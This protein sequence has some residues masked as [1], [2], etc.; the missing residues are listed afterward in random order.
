MIFTDIYLPALANE[1]FL[2]LFCLSQIVLYLSEH[3]AKNT[4][5]FIAE[6]HRRSYF[7]ETI[8][9]FIH[10]VVT[11]I[12]CVLQLSFNNSWTRIIYSWSAN[13]SCAYFT[14]HGLNYVIKPDYPN[15]M[16]YALHHLLGFLSV[17]PITNLNGYYLNDTGDTEC[18]DTVYFV[19]A[20]LHLVEISTIWLDARIFAQLWLKRKLYFA[21]TVLLVA[22]YFPLRVIWLAYLMYIIGI[23]KQQ[24]DGCFGPYAVYVLFTTF[25]FILLMSFVYSITMLRAGSRFFNLKHY[26]DC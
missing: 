25:G 16:V 11:S 5:K 10:A 20:G 26:K 14:V 18:S 4:K 8:L 21:S 17:V 7:A 24:F 1:S 6:A 22:T 23:S 3:W 12:T 2:V 19:S 9:S 13:V 15:S